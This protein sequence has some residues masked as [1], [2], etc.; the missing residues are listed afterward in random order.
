[1]KVLI[2]GNFDS[3]YIPIAHNSADAFEAL[4]CTVERFHSENTVPGTTYF[5]MRIAKSLAK[6]IGKKQILSDYFTHIIYKSRR[7]RFLN[8]VAEFGPDVVF[9]MQFNGFDS[10]TLCKLRESMVTVSWMLEP[11]TTEQ[12]REDIKGYDLYY[13]M[14][15]GHEN[16]GATYLAAF[17][18]D[19]ITFQPGA[20]SKDV[21]LLFVGSWS[22]RRQRWLESISELSSR[23]I[24]IGRHWRKQL[25]AGHP[26]FHSVVAEGVDIE[27][28]KFWYQRAQVVINIHRLEVDS[29]NGEG[30]NL[31]L[32]DVP[33]C[34]TVLLTEYSVDLESFFDMKDEIVVFKT[35]KELKEQCVRL[36]GDSALRKDIE[37]SGLRAVKRIG[38]YKDRMR[39][40]LNDISKIKKYPSRVAPAHYQVSS[41]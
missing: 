10:T 28:L 26:L 27:S 24:I 4:G 13:S 9:V 20:K 16:A 40:V 12:V 39:V 5:F 1:M 22:H 14:H 30:G 23:L 37:E 15:K 36:E 21:P 29:S 41:S 19:P 11:K 18:Y 7:K 8:A 35:Q 6:L 3:R 33:A 32:A 31:R 2:A 17:A 34:K 25:G 38:T